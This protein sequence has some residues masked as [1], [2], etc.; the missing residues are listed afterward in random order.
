MAP[1]VATMAMVGPRAPAPPAPRPRPEDPALAA[2]GMAL[3][4]PIGIL[5]GPSSAIY[6]FIAYV[7]G[8]SGAVLGFTEPGS[9]ERS[10]LRKVL[11]FGLLPIAAYAF[12]QRSL[13]LPDWD[14]TWLRGDPDSRASATPSRARSAPSA[15]STARGRWRRCWRSRCCATSPCGGRGR[16]SS[17][18]PILIVVALSLTFVRSAWVAL[19]A[20]GAGARHRLPRAR[21]R[22]SC[23]AARPIVVVAAIALSPVSNTARDVVD[24]FRSINTSG[25]TSSEERSATVERDAADRARGTAGPRDGQCRRGVQAQRR[26]QPARPRQRLPAACSTRSGSSASRSSS[27][28]WRS[29]SEPPG[30][31]PGRGRRAR[32]SGSSSSR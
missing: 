5:H 13:H 31:A 18:A 24:R 17:P 27:R 26:L 15:R 20:A 6:A 4:L 19:I 8:V 21:A 1:F 7:A 16:S 9:V 14:R 30:T 12:Y 25:D 29:C 22:A 11:L 32:T 2:A 3:G 23:S 10:A 28:R